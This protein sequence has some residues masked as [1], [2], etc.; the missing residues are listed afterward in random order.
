[1][2]DAVLQDA[3]YAVRQLRR[4]PWFTVAVVATLALGIGVNAA[5]Y[6]LLSALL[7][8]PLPVK[9]PRRLVVLS[10]TDQRGQD[11]RLIYTDTFNELRTHQRVFESMSMYSGGGVLTTEARGVMVPASIEGGT[12]EY[13]G[14]LGVRPYLGR[15]ITADDAPS[16]GEAA[17]V[18]ILGYRFWQRNYGG[19]AHAIG[20]QFIVDGFPLTIIGI[21]PPEFPGLYVE[22]GADFSV[23]MS[24]VRR[25]AGDPKRPIRARNLIARLRPDVTLDQAR[26]E[27]AAIWP[28]IQAAT[29]PPGFAAREQADM[30]AQQIHLESLANGFSTLRTRYANPLMVLLALAALLLVIGCVNL[31]G[32]LLARAVARDQQLAICLALGATRGRLIQQLLVESLLLSVLGAI[33]AIPL[34]WWVSR[35]LSAAIRTSGSPLARPMTPDAGV[36][37]VMAAIAVSAGLLVGVLPAWTAT[38]RRDHI[39]L[40][41]HRLVTSST[42]WWGRSLLVAQVALSLVLLVGAGLFVKSLAKLRAID[43]GYTTI[44]IVWTRVTSLPGGYRNL[45]AGSYYPAL[46]ER[47]STLPGVRSVALTHFFPAYFGF[48]LPP[49]PIARTDDASLAADG[50]MEAVSPRFFETVGIS[51]LQGRDFTWHD[52][53]QTQAVAI[54]NESLVRK[55]FPAGDAIGQR[56]DLG[57]DDKRRGIII[58][59]VTRDAVIGNL[60]AGAHVPVA[61]RP[62]LQEPVYLPVPD[63][64]VRASGDVRAVGAAIQRTVPTFGREYVR[65]TQTLDEQFDLTLL[66]ERLLATLSS[67]FAGLALLLAFIG[68][69]ALLAY[70]VSRRTREIGVRMAL[71]ASRGSVLR[72]IVRESVALTVIGVVIGMPCALATTRL[73]GRLLF[74][75]SPAD[76]AT[77]VGASVFFVVVGALAGLRPAH[78]A[79]TIDPMAALR[80]D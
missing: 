2:V 46:V 67:S 74:G 17:P 55:L 40:Q 36:L 56:I 76:P 21:T 7:L 59:G 61:F 60:K 25:L 43:A 72:M 9:D 24:V 12:P 31:S 35:G 65:R 54:V 49:Q 75:L 57:I 15:F 23:P 79:S 30:K 53:A 66:Q 8:R 64:V 32:L 10:V 63:V 3:R 62:T 13:Y 18:V 1:M 73:T 29:I 42:S 48:D 4:S 41:A 71:G 70:A 27:I 14:V 20:E 6:S 33:A 47:L 16:V 22:A 5:L 44:G 37:A 69:Y 11:A 28:S 78:R 34:S 26:A 58:V 45:D 19:D 51:L 68:L 52:N 77:L 50:L 80:C 39:G 38:R